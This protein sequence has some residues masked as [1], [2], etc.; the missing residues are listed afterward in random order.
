M[1]SSVKRCIKL[2]STIMLLLCTC[3]STGATVGLLVEDKNQQVMGFQSE[4]SKLRPSDELN[5]YTLKSLPKNPKETKVT[6]WLAMGAK[7]LATLLSRV[8]NTK[9]VRILGLFIRSEAQ[10]KLK[11][12]FPNKSFSLLD[13]SPPLTRQLALI[14]VLSPHIKSVAIFYTN[15]APVNLT[16]LSPLAKKLG[17]TIKTA[18]IN[19]PLNWE[20]A[21]LKVLKET[22]VVLG[23]NEP[24]IYNATTIRSILMRLYRASRPLLGP[25][26]GYVR[27]GAV[28]STYSGVKETIKAVAQIL[29]S[30]QAL[31]S[32]V[33][34]PHFNVVVNTQVAR[35]LD[36]NVVDVKQ[37]SQQVREVLNEK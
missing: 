12:L 14:K 24:A 4:L 31:P 36:I 34:N 23:V 13:N 1:G 30:E 28:A 29:S 16:N 7:P 20:R 17:L 18:A 3:Y 6:T 32:I 11:K 35:S 26:K 25:D 8:D 5:L 19:D 22:D 9:D 33:Q 2:I 15:E 21:S 37:L 27:A 10:I